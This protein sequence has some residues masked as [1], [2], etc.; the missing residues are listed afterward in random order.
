MTKYSSSGNETST[1][2]VIV[3]PLTRLDTV[4]GLTV[5]KSSLVGQMGKLKRQAYM[6]LSA[7][8]GAEL[9][10]MEKSV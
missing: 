8:V 1:P 4:P 2:P 10:W 5:L 3:Q 9:E 6:R 7:T